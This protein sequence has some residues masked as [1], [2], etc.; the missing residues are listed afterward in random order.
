MYRR[1]G[2]TLGQPNTQ[3]SSWWISIDIIF[4]TAIPSQNRTPWSY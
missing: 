3:H 1:L 2:F 4:V